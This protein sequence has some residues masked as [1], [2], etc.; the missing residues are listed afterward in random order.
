MKIAEKYLIKFDELKVGQKVWN[1]GLGEVTV[2][3]ITKNE[4]YPILT[5]TSYG[6]RTFTKNGYS[7]IDDKYPTLFLSCPY[8]EEDLPEFGEEVCAWDDDRTKAD[9]VKF[10]GRTNDDEK[11]YITT[12]TSISYSRNI[13]C[14][15]FKNI[16]RIAPLKELTM[17]EKVN[18][19]WE[20]FNKNQ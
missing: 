19:M 14:F 16:E 11:S 20:F 13:N 10:L 6:E 5:S 4:D 8:E 1:A 2:L 9:R 15:L 12:A 7:M 3:D 17:E 18:Q